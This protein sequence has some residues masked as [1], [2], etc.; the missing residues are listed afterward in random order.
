MRFYSIQ[1]MSEPKKTTIRR[2]IIGLFFLAAPTRAE[3][4]SVQITGGA[5]SSGNN[6]TWT[7]KNQSTQGI[8]AVEF[9]HFGADLFLA[10]PGWKV[11]STGLITVGVAESSG[12]CR[13]SFE[14]SRSGFGPGRSAE[15]TMRVPGRSSVRGPAGVT[16]YFADG[17]IATIPNVEVPRPAPAGDQYIS[18]I[19][20]GIIFAALI[21][22]RSLRRNAARL[23]TTASQKS[24][25]H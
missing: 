13:A 19:G 18:L 25:S 15:F 3:V 20:L 17:T 24:P 10:P 7:L 1:E 2:A 9:P 14:E 4:P 5:D 6:Y 16:V 8:L 11:E 22:F 23:S 12:T 21:L